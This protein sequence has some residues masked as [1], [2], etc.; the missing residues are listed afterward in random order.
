MPNAAFSRITASGWR[1]KKNFERLEG[2][3]FLALRFFHVTRRCYCLTI[4]LS[5]FLLIL[6]YF[7]PVSRLHVLPE[8][9]HR[10]PLFDYLS[11]SPPTLGRA[12][13][14]AIV[15]FLIGIELPT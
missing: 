3:L 1:R 12:F 13:V 15:C 8:M 4:I 6:C 7:Y 10:G 2:G 14:V 5:T 11:S 9:P